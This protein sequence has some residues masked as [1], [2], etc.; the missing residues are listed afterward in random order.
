MIYD[1]FVWTPELRKEFFKIVLDNYHCIDNI[2]EASINFV[3]EKMFK[4][5]G[6]KRTLS[7]IIWEIGNLN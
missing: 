7:D 2:E 1:N 5:N 4:N 3:K 6:T